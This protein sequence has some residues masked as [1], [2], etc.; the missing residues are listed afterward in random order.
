MQVKSVNP[1]ILFAAMYFAGC[2]SSYGGELPGNKKQ[3]NPEIKK[4]NDAIALGMSRTPFRWQQDRLPEIQ[5]PMFSVEYA[6]LDDI[7]GAILNGQNIV[8]SIDEGHN[9]GSILGRQVSAKNVSGS[10]KRVVDLLSKNVGFFYSYTD[11]VLHVTPPAHYT[12]PFSR[13]RSEITDDGYA[14]LDEL[15]P[16]ISGGNIRV[17]GRPDDVVYTKTKYAMIAANRARNIRDYLTGQGIPSSAITVTVDKTP[18]TRSN[19]RIY[20]C[21]IY[22]GGENSVKRS[23]AETFMNRAFAADFSRL[24]TPQYSQS[25]VYS[26]LRPPVMPQFRRADTLRTVRA[27]LIEM[28]RGE[29]ENGEMDSAVANEVIGL[30][31]DSRPQAVA[32]SVVAPDART[33]TV[34]VI[35][36]ASPQPLFVAAT[37]TVNKKLWRLEPNLSLR[38]NIDAR[39]V[40]E[41]W[42]PTQWLASNLY[43]VTSA[44]T[45]EG[46]FLGVLHQISDA[47]KLNFCVYARDKQIRVTDPNVSCKS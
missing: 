25:L 15:I 2:T 14:A 11:G 18:N 8:Y 34:E 29:A 9:V 7:L 36:T 32:Q 4:A 31:S 16:K 19:A 28:V 37:A 12:I 10:L 40:G 27:K 24:Y 47:T 42:H 20:P 45:L 46:D 30:L 1:L 38:E 5:I 41:G 22:I 23:P 13:D 39:A 21:D 35:P 43:Q 6:T 33:S 44:V 3:S 17:V 26:E